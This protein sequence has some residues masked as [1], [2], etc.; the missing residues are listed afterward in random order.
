MVLRSDGT[1]VGRIGPCA[2]TST[3]QTRG[4]M[5]QHFVQLD[6]LQNSDPKYYAYTLKSE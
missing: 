1:E 3:L 5:K 4:S 2:R 6:G